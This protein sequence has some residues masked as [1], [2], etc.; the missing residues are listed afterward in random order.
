LILPSQARERETEEIEGTRVR[1]QE[2]T[3]NGQE[4]EQ[5]PT[6]QGMQAPEP[7]QRDRP[8]SQ[9]QRDILEL[10]QLIQEATGSINNVVESFHQFKPLSHRGLTKQ[11]QPKESV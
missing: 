9:K 4:L 2:P 6:K 8:V 10:A 1:F 7:S 3:T 5:T 11:P